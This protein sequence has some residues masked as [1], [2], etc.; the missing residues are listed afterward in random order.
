ME[1]IK[2]LKLLSG[3]EIVAEVTDGG[4]FVIVKNP[5][6]FVMMPVNSSQVGVE[7]HPF[8]MLSKDDEVELSKDFI[9]AI[10]NPIDEI[11]QSYKSQFSAIVTPPEKR[12]IT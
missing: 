1:Q 11:L 4:S 9:I 5:V 7:M 10:C 2:V 8:I 12:L 6:K 3:E